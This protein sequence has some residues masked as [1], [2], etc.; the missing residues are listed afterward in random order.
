MLE[1]VFRRNKQ[2][3]DTMQLIGLQGEESVQQLEQALS[4]IDGVSEVAV[5]LDDEKIKVTY[6]SAQTNL[7]T[8]QSAIKSTGLEALKPVHGEDGNCCGGCT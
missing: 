4:S 6:N 1:K 8:L 2:K 7:P 3:T 5:S